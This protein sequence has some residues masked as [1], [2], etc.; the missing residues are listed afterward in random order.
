MVGDG[1]RARPRDARAQGRGARGGG[2]AC[3]HGGM[4]GGQNAPTTRKRAASLS[5]ISQGARE[6]KRARL[7]DD[8]AQGMEGR[9]RRARQ[10]SSR[11]LGEDP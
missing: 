9:P 4:R 10:P 3:G 6:D 11:S 8:A 5:T 1:K 7:T 2:H